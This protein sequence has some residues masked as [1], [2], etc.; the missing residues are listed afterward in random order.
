MKSNIHTR[1]LVADLRKTKAKV[2]IRIADE[3][4][5]STR[6][7]HSVNIYKINKVTRENEI[8]VIPGKVLGVGNLDKKITVA[9]FQFSETALEKINKIGKAISLQ[10]AVKTNP[11]GQKVRIL[12]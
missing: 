6:I 3:L 10:E 11:K 2:W 4:E 5:R 8:A 12:K 1:K 7:M 9:A